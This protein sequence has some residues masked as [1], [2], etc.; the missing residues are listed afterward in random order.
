MQS[1]HLSTAGA[2][3]LDWSTNGRL[4]AASRDKHLAI[5]DVDRG[6]KKPVALIACHQGSKPWKAVFVDDSTVVT[7]GFGLEGSKE[8]A[9]WDLVRDLVLNFSSSLAY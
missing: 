5:F 9:I 3:S 6:E 4:A 7:V 8:V 1:V 2:Y